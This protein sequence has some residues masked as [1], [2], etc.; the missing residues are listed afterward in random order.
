MNLHHY[1]LHYFSRLPELADVAA[2]PIREGVKPCEARLSPESRY[3]GMKCNMNFIPEKTSMVVDVTEIRSP[4]DFKGL[5]LAK[6][7]DGISMVLAWELME[8][9]ISNNRLTTSIQIHP[10]YMIIDASGQAVCIK[11][12]AA[13]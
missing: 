9:P 13:Q 11:E 10:T 12:T 3:R 1:V 8:C 5:E 4:F 7:L 2:V 6:N